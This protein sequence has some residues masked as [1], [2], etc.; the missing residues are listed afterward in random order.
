MTSTNELWVPVA[1]RRMVVSLSEDG[2]HWYDGEGMP[3]HEVPLKEKDGMRP[4]TIRDA[5]TLNLSPSVT[6]VMGILK[7]KSIDDWSNDL[8]TKE[9]FLSPTFKDLSGESY[10]EYKQRI[11][12]EVS[13]KKKEAPEFGSTYHNYMEA[14]A[15]STIQGVDSKFKPLVEATIE[16]LGNEGLRVVWAEFN[17]KPR[18]TGVGGQ[19]DLIAWSERLQKHIIADYKTVSTLKKDGTPKPKWKPYESHRRQISRYKQGLIQM[20]GEKY[21]DS[22]CLIIGVS[23]DQPGRV[24]PYYLSEEEEAKALKEFEAIYGCW[25]AIKNYYPNVE[26]K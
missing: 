9:T 23:K 10:D 4:T 18:L 25:K 11:Y 24:I 6:N 14:W 16:F 20:F 22:L 7:N 17:L 15:K 1:Q 8:L 2:S 13:K 21:E 19:I 12:R 3:V 26:E 5:R